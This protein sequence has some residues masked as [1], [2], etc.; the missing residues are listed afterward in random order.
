MEEWRHWLE[1]AGQLFIIWTDHK[2]LEY[3]G[4]AKRLNS[5][6]ARW[7]LF[8]ARFNL[9]LSYRPGSCNVSVDDWE[10]YGPEERCGVPA[11]NVVDPQLIRD[12]HRHHPNPPSVRRPRGKP[13]GVVAFQEEGDGGVDSDIVDQPVPE[14]TSSQEFKDAAVLPSWFLGCQ[15]MSH[16]GGESLFPAN[17][18]RQGCRHHTK[19]TW[20]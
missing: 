20:N 6:Q 14:R 17:I 16:S 2:N 18:I 8:F 9:S 19:H 13:R 1:G 15:V 12:F 4:T 3:I 7:A 10:G 11:Q 5:R